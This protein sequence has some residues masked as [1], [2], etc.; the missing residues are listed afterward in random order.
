MAVTPEDT[1]TFTNLLEEIE[2]KS[3]EAKSLVQG[4]TKKEHP[5]ENGLSF[6]EVKNHVMLN[7][8]SNLTLLMLKKCSGKSIKDSKAIERI[9][10]DRTI[11]EKMRPIEKKLKYQIDKSIKVAESGQLSADDPL[12]FKP[13]LSALKD[14]LNS[15]ED[16]G[17][18]DDDEEL[19]DGDKKDKKYVPPKNVPA[20]VDDG[21]TLEKAEEDRVKKRSLSKSIM[22]DLR[23]QHLDLPEEEHSHVDTMKAKQIAHMKERIRYE[24]DNYTRL[25]L[26]KK[27]KHKRR[28]ISTMGT[29]G[30]ELTNFGD[31]FFNEA[32]KRKTSSS[33]KK[34][35]KGG[36]SAK[37]KFKR[38]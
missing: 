9:C 30:D 34:F 38:K 24:E 37:K 23:R 20:F 17:D 35:S 29:L 1:E 14:T 13:N 3:N 21:E 15:D 22:E 11:L 6:L 4:L 36:S 7:Y 5:T 27:D 19:K 28:Q 31:N 10:E 25:P 2:G 18:E 33:A 32:K 16:S 26:T 8:L 12:N